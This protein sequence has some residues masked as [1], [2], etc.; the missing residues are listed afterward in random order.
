M[1]AEQSF[2]YSFD[3]PKAAFIVSAP[4]SSRSKPAKS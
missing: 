4:E 3:A 2:E 1:K